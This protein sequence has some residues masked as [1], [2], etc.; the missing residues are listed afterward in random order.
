MRGLAAITLPV[1]GLPPFLSS[2]PSDCR[3]QFEFLRA[4]TGALKPRPPA[5]SHLVQVIGDLP[6]HTG[7]KIDQEFLAKKV[8]GSPATLFRAVTGKDP[9]LRMKLLSRQ[10]VRVTPPRHATSAKTI[11]DLLGE[12]FR[13]TYRDLVRGVDSRSASALS[14]LPKPV[15][16]EILDRIKHVSTLRNQSPPRWPR[17]ILLALILGNCRE[18]ARALESISEILWSMGLPLRAWLV[19]RQ[20]HLYNELGWETHEPAFSKDELRWTL[21]CMHN[22]NTRIPPGYGTFSYEALA[23]EAHEPNL[24]KTK[25]MVKRI[26]VLSRSPSQFQRWPTTRLFASPSEWQWEV[27]P[28]STTQLDPLRTLGAVLHNLSQ[29]SY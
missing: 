10:Y 2:R 5:H 28:D 22:L 9:S 1:R 7:S 16:E 6:N 14:A 26:C 11:A 4:L 20:E 15:L 21:E 8:K 27:P 23:A 12:D 3:K 25:R 19:E 24:E 13:E 17:D 29:P 18:N